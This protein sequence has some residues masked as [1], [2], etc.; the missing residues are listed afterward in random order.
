MIFPNEIDGLN[1][2]LSLVMQIL[3]MTHK[4]RYL[5]KDETDNQLN[6]FDGAPHDQ[7]FINWQYY[8]IAVQNLK[9]EYNSTLVLN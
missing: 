9:T 5:T 2:L 3:F 8:I 1:K 6:F 4:E 7:I